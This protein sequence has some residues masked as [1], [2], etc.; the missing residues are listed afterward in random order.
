MT[1]VPSFKQYPFDGHDELC[2][3]LGRN[4]TKRVL[5]V[6]PLFDEMN[7]M[8][9]IL[10]DVM[11]NLESHKISSFL[12]DL[13]G[14]NESRLQLEDMDVSRWQ[15]AV[16]VCS[17]QMKTKHI[18]SV[19]GGA[20]A[21]PPSDEISHWMLAP[22]KGSALLRTMMRSRVAGDKEAGKETTIAGLATEAESQAIELAGNI[23][24]PGMYQSLAE[25]KPISRS[26]QRIVRLKNDSKEADSRIEG[27]AIWL[28][29]EPD[30]DP[31]LSS[32]MAQN[33]AD[34]VRQ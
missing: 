24:S 30:S 34:W 1:S 10:V 2:L 32:A 17:E 22:V 11:R 31:V 9:R 15:Q 25:A 23:I 3:S 7:R 20:L 14:T 19:R 28:R 27:S 6:P 4:H 5:I 8:R 13:P 33:I 21:L 26:N 16:S 12:M 18:A 29:A